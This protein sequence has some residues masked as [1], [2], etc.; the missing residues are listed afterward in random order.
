MIEGSICYHRFVIDMLAV[1]VILD[2][3]NEGARKALLDASQFL[4][5]LGVFEGLIPEIGDW[6]GGRMLVATGDRHD[7]RGATALG[8]ALCGTG[9]TKSWREEFDECAYYV[10]AGKPVEAAAAEQDGHDVGGGIARA[11]RGPFT[12][13]LRF[14]SAPSHQHAD[15]G[16]IV[17]MHEGNPL[18][19]DPG[20]G[21]YNGDPETRDHFRATSSHGTLELD[22]T[23]QLVP[24]RTFRYGT[25]AGGAIGPPIS[26]AEDTVIAWGAHDAYRRLPGKPIVVRAVITHPNHVVSIDFV[27]G[28]GAATPMRRTA[29]LPLHPTITFEANNE[30]LELNDFEIVSSQAVRREPARI[31]RT[32]ADVQATSA[33]ATTSESSVPI[34]LGLAA[35]GRAPTINIEDAVVTCGS[36]AVSAEVV[37]DFVR[38]SVSQH[39][40][41]FDSKVQIGG[42]SWFTSQPV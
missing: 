23:D 6:D 14:G 36:V 40:S 11:Q 2:P 7:L 4:C 39:S 31:S 42:A 32:L 21:T 16:S 27:I 9:A 22:D 17:V 35:P 34:V 18:V 15:L 33:L 28:A 13:F 41:H 3:D 5:R 1:R 29:R 24:T 20:T 10:G 38:L 37:G 19:I 25:I 12:S 30:A 26:L 8:L